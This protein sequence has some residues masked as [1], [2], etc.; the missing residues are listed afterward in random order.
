M[1]F[2]LFSKLSLIP[3]AS[4]R[5]E[6]LGGEIARMIKPY[7]DGVSVDAIGNVIAFKKGSGGKKIMVAAH[8]DEVALKIRYIDE[9]GF[10]YFTLTGGIDPRTLL[11]QRV[12]VQTEE[13]G[14]IPGVIGAKAAHYLTAAEKT[15]P[16]DALS[17]Y[18][19]CGFNFEEISKIVSIGDPV[20]LDRTPAELG[21][22]LF[23]AKAIDDR[24]GVYIL[25][26]V[27]K[28]MPKEHKDD[29]YFVFTVQEEYGLIGAHGAVMAIR[30]DVALAV[31][32]TGALD[33]PG[34]R[35]QDY[36]VSLGKGVGI[37]LTDGTTIADRALC[38]SLI[39]ICK[40]KGIAYQ[41]RVAARGSNDAKAMQRESG[42]VKAAALSVP[43]RYIH[44]NVE[45]ASKHDID[46]AYNLVLNFLS[47][48]F[49]G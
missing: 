9:K 19:D 18:I 37:T 48:G 28:N 49:E 45:T 34:M 1:D 30:P 35:P 43:V 44:S 29:I 26:Q 41:L 5:E 33:T 47:E 15:Q 42:P 2:D 38:K 3:A 39:K 31:D 7:C 11:S 32:T 40:D 20:V 27:I 23:T 14:L 6:L 46:A 4:G 24:A 36:V 10:L 25:V 13:N 22:G 21:G 16:L 8:M 12:L 17:L